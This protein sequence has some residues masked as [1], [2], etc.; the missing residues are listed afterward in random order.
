VSSRLSDLEERAWQALLHSH[1]TVTRQLEADLR[2]QHGLLLADYDILR[3]LSTGGGRLSMTELAERVLAPISTLSRRIDGLVSAGYVV[4]GRSPD[5]ARYARARVTF[6]SLKVDCLDRARTSVDR[7][8][9][10]GLDG[11]ERCASPRTD[12]AKRALSGRRAGYRQNT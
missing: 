1:A 10:L 2:K 11:P 4:R 7:A 9:D 12:R 5:N 8:F 6:A 3:R